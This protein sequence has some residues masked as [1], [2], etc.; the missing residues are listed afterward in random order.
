MKSE[1]YVKLS[2]VRDYGIGKEEGDFI[3]HLSEIE[4]LDTSQL[5]SLRKIFLEEIDDIDYQ[6]KHENKHLQHDLKWHY[7]AKSSK[8]VRLDFIE[9]IDSVLKDNG[10]ISDEKMLS[11]F[12]E[13][14]NSILDSETLSKINDEIAFRT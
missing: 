2:R 10:I 3:L 13:V 4:L 7:G 8:R 11:L 1:A 14:A 6:I 5:Q 9:H 12:H